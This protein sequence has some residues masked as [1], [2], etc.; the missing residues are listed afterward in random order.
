MLMIPE[1][2]RI[3]SLLEAIPEQGRKKICVLHRGFGGSPNAARS[4][5]ELLELRP[6][7][8]VAIFQPSQQQPQ[9]FV[10]LPGGERIH[11]PLDGIESVWSQDGGEWAMTLRG[12]IDVLFNKPRYAPR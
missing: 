11:V 12:K 3:A 7:D 1:I 10:P 9:G 8:N 2:R 5:F 4:N 6:T